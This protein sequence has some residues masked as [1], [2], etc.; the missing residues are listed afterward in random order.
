MVIAIGG[1]GAELAELNFTEAIKD[2]PYFRLVCGG[3]DGSWLIISGSR[4][5]VHQHEKHFERV[6]KRL[7]EVRDQSRVLLCNSGFRWSSCW[8]QPARRVVSMFQLYSE[9]FYV[10]WH[11]GSIELKASCFSNL[12]ACVNGLW[13][14]LDIGDDSDIDRG[15]PVF[16]VAPLHHRPPALFRCIT[17]LQGYLRFADPG[18]CTEQATF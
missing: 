18:G 15:M 14:D 5:E 17:G 2:S 12:T 1:G 7:E 11:A 6:Q 16:P 9:L 13:A 4:Y 10:D 3:L 8:T